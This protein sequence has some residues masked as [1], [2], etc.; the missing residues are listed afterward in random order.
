MQSL[1]IKMAYLISCIKFLEELGIYQKESIYYSYD[2]WVN[3]PDHDNWDQGGE[4]YYVNTF[5]ENIIMKLDDIT[6]EGKILILA[7]YFLTS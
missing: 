2:Y 3:N 7:L 5:Y 4:D 1:L 6:K